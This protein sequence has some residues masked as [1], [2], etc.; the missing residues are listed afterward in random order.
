MNEIPTPP[1]PAFK[2]LISIRGWKIRIR[3]SEKLGDVRL[4]S[5]VLFSCINVWKRNTLRFSDTPW[6]GIIGATRSFRSAAT[7][8]DQSMVV[9]P[10][11]ALEII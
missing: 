11:E 3:T 5:Q 1:H 9:R 7:C 10:T 4:Q 6:L 8:T 2:N